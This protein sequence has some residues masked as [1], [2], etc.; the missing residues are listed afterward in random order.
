MRAWLEKMF[1]SA[2]IPPYEINEHTINILYDLMQVNQE[3]D[4]ETTVIIDDLN[5]KAEEYH[6]EG[7]N[8]MYSTTL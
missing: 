6:S 4:K 8:V 1:T 2:D 3:R 7:K 5:Q